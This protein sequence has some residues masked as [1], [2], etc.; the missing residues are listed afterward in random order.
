M[1]AMLS[2]LFFDAFLLWVVMSVRFVTKKKNE[3]K[4]VCLGWLEPGEEP[5]AVFIQTTDSFIIYGISSHLVS[6]EF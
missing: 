6:R 2:A 3:V 5:S 4:N 1:C